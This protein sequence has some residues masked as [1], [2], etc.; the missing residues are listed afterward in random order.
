MFGCRQIALIY[1]ALPPPPTVPL[2]DPS[3]TAHPRCD[4][5]ANISTQALMWNA[6]INNPVT[7]PIVSQY[8]DAVSLPYSL[9][10]WLNPTNPSRATTASGPAGRGENAESSSQPLRLRPQTSRQPKRPQL[11]LPVSRHTSRASP[12]PD[13]KL[14][15]ILK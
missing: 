12:E 8:S 7:A 2:I 11:G 6:L 3:G 4:F 10:M 1:G 13:G 15:Q 5:P 14:S 9:P